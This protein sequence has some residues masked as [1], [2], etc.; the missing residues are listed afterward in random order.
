MHGILTPPPEQAS[1]LLR[2]SLTTSRRQ[3]STTIGLIVFFA[4]IAL[5]VVAFKLA[6][7]MFVVPP[8]LALNIR[9]GEPMR[10]DDSANN[11]FGVFV[12]VLMLVLMAAIGSAIANRGIKL[13][14][15]NDSTPKDEEK[16]KASA[17]AVVN[18]D[19]PVTKTE[20]SKSSPEA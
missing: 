6:Y 16:R 4:G 7:D 8:E 19:S 15:V 14:S 5:V 3:G 1:L 12:R 10:L 18:E 20:R 11:M 13:Y 9:A 2:T 17:K